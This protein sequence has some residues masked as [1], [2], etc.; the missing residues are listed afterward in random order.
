MRVEN[1]CSFSTNNSIATNRTNV[2]FHNYKSKPDSVSF[3]ANHYETA[4]GLLGKI[5]DELLPYINPKAAK[6]KKEAQEAQRIAEEKARALKWKQ[7]Q[8]QKRQTTVEE[9]RKILGDWRTRHAGLFQERKFVDNTGDLIL[10]EEESHSD[11]LAKADKL[12]R[13]DSHEYTLANFGIHCGYFTENGFGQQTRFIKSDGVYVTN[14]KAT[15]TPKWQDKEFSDYKWRV[16]YRWGEK[17][18]EGGRCPCTYL[19]CGFYTKKGDALQRHAGVNF[20]IEGIIPLKDLQQIKKNIVEKGLW[21]H[22]IENQDQ[23]AHIAIY[24]EI[25]NYLNNIK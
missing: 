13:P 6:L 2:R 4:K 1:N 8:A 9:A 23:D 21:Q 20:V 19:S 25:I 3:G 12:I 22:Y 24:N 17:C 16:R 7:E 11:L 5:W 15:Y 10:C 14:I 18:Y